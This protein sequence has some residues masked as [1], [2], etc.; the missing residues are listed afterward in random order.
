MRGLLAAALVASSC[1]STARAPG[2]AAAPDA[3]SSAPDAGTPPA[4]PAV[5][6]VD[7]DAP[8]PGNAPT[9]LD[10]DT[11]T[12]LAVSRD[13]RYAVVS[14]DVLRFCTNN[15]HSGP[16][17]DPSYDI[18]L[19]LVTAGAASLALGVSGRSAEFSR[20]SR[21]LFVYGSSGRFIAH[22]DGTRL[23][24]NPPYSSVGRWL[25]SLRGGDL[26]RQSD[27]D[28]DASVVLAATDNA[29]AVLS[30]DGESIAYCP[31]SGCFLQSPI[32]ALPLPIR[33]GTVMWWAPEGTWLFIYPCT[34]VD[35]PGRTASVC[36]SIAPRTWA[37]RAGDTI[38]FV[39]AG[40][41]GLDVHVRNLVTSTEVVFPAAPSAGWVLLS[42]DARRVVSGVAE[43]TDPAG[44][45]TLL[46]APSSGGPWT[47]LGSNVERWSMSADSRF[48]GMAR[49]QG[50]P[51]ISVDG[52]PGVEVGAPGLDL[53]GGLAPMFEPADGFGKAVFYEWDP[54]R[55]G[56]HSV[57]GNADGSG[58]WMRLPKGA[59]CLEWRGHTALCWNGNLYAV[60]GEQTG[61]LARGANGYTVAPAAGK[62]FFVGPAGLSS[63]DLPGP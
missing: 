30:P 51:Q 23:R 29:G 5:R 22:A 2:G 33:S 16:P 32:G 17:C 1:V 12:L 38:A 63:V 34:Y 42:P 6:E 44:P 7:P 8:Y 35:L 37:Q 59:D 43:S 18:P 26:V 14:N 54:G 55:M 15:P 58:D 62:I 9:L 57:I 52:A 50:Q 61:L 39:S 11:K 46:E 21:F 31:S 25:Y 20:D 4:T 53:S 60:R 56:L 19:R 13:G 24:P 49:L 47:T 48:V 10:G 40:S 3:G 28:D 45:V 41:A 27:L 36:D